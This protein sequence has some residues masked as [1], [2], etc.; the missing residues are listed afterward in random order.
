MKKLLLVFVS[1]LLSS[2]AMATSP[3]SSN[4]GPWVDC[5]YQD[6]SV[7]YEPLMMCEMKGGKRKY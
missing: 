2:G 4:A 1:L 5:L 6:G 3:A 7:N